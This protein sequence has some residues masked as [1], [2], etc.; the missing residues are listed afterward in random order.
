MAALRRDRQPWWTSWRDIADYY[1]PKRYVWLLSDLERSRYLSKNPNILDAT[2]TTAGRVLAA[3]MMNGITS[4]SRPWF[5]IRL[6]NYKDDLDNASRRWLDEVERRML[7]VMAESNAYNCLAVMYLDLVFFGTASM[8]VYEDYKTVIRCYNN[9][10]GEYFLGQDH[11]HQVNTFAREFTYKVHQVVDRWGKEN[12]S[13]RVKLAYAAGNARMQEDVQITCLVQP[14]IKKDGLVP[15]KFEFCE[16]YYET[17]GEVGTILEA[18]GYNE[19]PGVFPRW[20][21]TGNDSYGT[22]P[23]HD[24]LGDVIQLQHETKRKGQSLDYMVRPPMVMDIQLQHRPTALLPGGQTFVAGLNNAGAKPAYQINPPIGELTL[25]I[26][27]IQAR[28]KEIFHNQLFNRVMTLDTVRSA[29]EIAKIDNEQLVLIGPVMQ[30]FQNEGLDPFINRTYNIMSRAN[31]L[32]EPPPNIA[33]AELEI[34]YVSMLNFAQSA[35]GVI[36]TERFLGLI[37]NVAALYPKAVNIPNW[38]DLLRDYARDIGVK[39]NGVNSRDETEAL[40]AQQD[41]AE[42]GDKAMAMAQPGADAAKLLSETQV[43][44]GSDALSMLMGA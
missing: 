2:G 14:N 12:C 20:E 39:A 7:L 10:L 26:K 25:D 1:L 28:I 5:K 44:G 24:A 31:L 16:I 18:V 3:G 43:G 32:P 27:D 19:M 37:G 30:R 6:K 13:E 33:D 40:G 15:K 9:A 34:Q 11:R 35:V 4:P 38:D 41:E 21:L 8:L 23:G 22:G 17:A 36:P 42:A 29:A